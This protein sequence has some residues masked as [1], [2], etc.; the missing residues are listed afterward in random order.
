MNGDDTTFKLGTPSLAYKK[1]NSQMHY[2]KN[3]HMT[4]KFSCENQYGEIRYYEASC[5]V[6]STKDFY[7]NMWD[8]KRIG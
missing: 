7:K 3:V 5:V 6:P 2:Y 1:G 4:Y 8:C